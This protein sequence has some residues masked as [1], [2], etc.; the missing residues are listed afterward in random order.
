[1]KAP[2]V[3]PWICALPLLF[4]NLGAQQ[5]VEIVPVLDDALAEAI[6][7]EG[8]GN[9]Q[10]MQYLKEFTDLSVSGGRLTGSDNY[11]EACYWALK[12]FEAM[13][14]DAHLEPWGE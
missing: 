3:Q 9:S 5:T 10:V 1:M 7:T 12:Q 8:I 13:G 14:L 4:A 6:R 11:T 2:D